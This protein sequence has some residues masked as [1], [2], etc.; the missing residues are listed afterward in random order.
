MTRLEFYGIFKAAASTFAFFLEAR[1]FCG[2]IFLP[3][4]C[5]S[6]RCSGALSSL[7]LCLTPSAG[8]NRKRSS[9][10]APVEVHLCG[11]PGQ[12]STPGAIGL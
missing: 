5:E 9:T 1:H 6:L 10:L 7:F 4:C 2:F 12:M 11:S 8:R 3:V